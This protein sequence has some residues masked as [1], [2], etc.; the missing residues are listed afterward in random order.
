MSGKRNG[1][2]ELEERG[3]HV[4]FAISMPWPLEN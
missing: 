2:R 4:I 1:K 3:K